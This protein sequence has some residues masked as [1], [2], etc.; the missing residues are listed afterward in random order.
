MSRSLFRFDVSHN[1]WPR[2]VSHPCLLRQYHCVLSQFVVMPCRKYSVYKLPV[3]WYGCNVVAVMVAKDDSRQ[4][5][6]TPTRQAPASKTTLATLHCWNRQ[7]LPRPFVTDV[8]PAPF[9]D[10]VSSRDLVISRPAKPAVSGPRPHARNTIGPSFHESQI[11]TASSQAAW[12]S[13]QEDWRGP[14]FWVTT[15]RVFT[16]TEPVSWAESGKHLTCSQNLLSCRR[17]S[18]KTVGGCVVNNSLAVQ[19]RFNAVVETKLS[20]AKSGQRFPC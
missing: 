6:L 15:G 3:L 2:P 1:E 12:L 17:G 9:I 19:A 14:H 8:P 7:P 16:E 4:Q 13:Q 10:L 5:K 18:S 11:A 20:H